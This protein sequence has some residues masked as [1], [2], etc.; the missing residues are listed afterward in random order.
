MLTSKQKPL[1]L[2]RSSLWKNYIRIS[3]MSTECTKKIYRDKINEHCFTLLGTISKIIIYA[4]ECS[5]RS[6]SYTSAQDA[7]RNRIEI[8]L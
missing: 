4:N 7:V 1:S 5:T 6:Q 2:T 3:E 8:A